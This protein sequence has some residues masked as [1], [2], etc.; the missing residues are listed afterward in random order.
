V[1]SEKYS[2]I[3]FPRHIVDVK[4]CRE[5]SRSIDLKKDSNLRH[6]K[7]GRAMIEEIIFAD[8][9]DVLQVSP[10]ADTDTIQRV[11]RH[12]A[13]RY[14]PD[15]PTGGNPELFR[16]IV[17]AHEILMDAEKRAAYDIRYQEYWDRK[18]RLLRD[19]GDGRIPRDNREIRERLLTLLY[20]QRR[21]STR[22][23]GLGEMDLAHL[24]RTPIE[25]I[26][27]DLW[28]LHRKGLVEKLESG[29]LAIS[30]AGVDHIEQSSLHLSEDRLLENHDTADK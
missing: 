22:H 14:H 21:T 16:E 15:S 6:K 27:F 17:K 8:Y 4:A 12:L 7:P 10:N 2:N 19:A 25:F 13:K 26:E 9:Y 30:V 20:V 28:Y 24:L 11:F 1:K 18:L 29:L 23:P 5:Y 3:E